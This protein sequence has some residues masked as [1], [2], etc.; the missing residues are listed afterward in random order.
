MPSAVRWATRNYPDLL[1][2]T[3]EDEIFLFN[4]RSGHTHLLN[5]VAAALLADLAE[6]PADLASLGARFH[7]PEGPLDLQTF[8]DALAQHLAQLQLIGLIRAIQ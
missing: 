5:P 4:P 8:T 3:W 2:E 6:Q 1:M 7:D